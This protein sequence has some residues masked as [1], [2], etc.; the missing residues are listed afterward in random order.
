MNNVFCIMQYIK[1]NNNNKKRKNFFA[2]FNDWF[3][4]K[5]NYTNVA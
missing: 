3:S 2:I 1:Q 5:C 4:S